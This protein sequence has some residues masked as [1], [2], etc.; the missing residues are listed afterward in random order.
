M[1][2]AMP[3]TLI[4]GQSWEHVDGLTLTCSHTTNVWNPG[5]LGVMGE[6]PT[7]VDQMV[8]CMSLVENE[9]T[10]SLKLL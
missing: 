3:E 8:Q 6:I 9:I 7:G 4:L 10:L 1:S 2:E 5:I